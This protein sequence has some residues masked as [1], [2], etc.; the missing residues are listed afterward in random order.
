MGD[1]SDPNKWHGIALGDITA[2]CIS[3]II[4]TRLTKYLTTFGIDEQCRSLFGNGCADAT[5]SLKLALQTIHEHNQEAFAL[6]VDLVKAYDT[7]NRE[8]LWKILQK[9]GIPPQMIKVLQK[10]Y[11]NVTYHMKIGGK[12]QIF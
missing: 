2:K 12:K 3:S 8:L 7:V 5:F 11:T 1:L 9:L 6:F 4:A 10:L